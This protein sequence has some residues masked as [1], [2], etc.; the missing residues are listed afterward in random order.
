MPFYE[1]LSECAMENEGAL[2]L[3][4]GFSLKKRQLTL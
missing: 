2:A 4:M 1:T 3:R